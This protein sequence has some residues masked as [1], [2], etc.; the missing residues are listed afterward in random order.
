MKRKLM[1]FLTCLFIGIGLVTAQTQTVTGIVI[2][3]EDGLPIAGASILVKGTSNGTI[4]EIDGKF[5][6]TNVPT[7]V[8]TLQVSYLGMIPQE[9]TIG[10]NLRVVLKSDTQML[11]EIVVTALGIKKSEKSIGFSAT[12]VSG[13]ELTA[14]GSK[15]VVQAMAGKIAGVQVSSNSSDP[16]ASSSIIVR[17]FSSLKGNNQPLFVV[18]GVPMNNTSVF[19]DDLGSGFDYGNGAN[20]V[21]PNDVESM[22]V[23]KG[24]AATALY[25]NRAANGVVLI[26]TKNGQKQEGIGIEYNLSLQTSDILRLPTFQNKYGIGWAGDHT[27]IENGSWGPVMDGSN[28]LWGN[29]Y[30]NSQKY[31][32]FSPIKDNVR[33]F[34]DYGFTYSNNLSFSGGNETTDYF[35]SVSQ[36]SDDG[37][38]PTDADLFDRF[39]GS[40]R[41]S[42]KFSIVKLSTS[43]NYAQ[44]T[45][46]FSP[47]G[48]GLTMINSIYQMPRDINIAALSDYKTDP[49]DTPDYYFTPY[50][51]TNPY[52][53][54]DNIQNSFEQKKIFGKIQADIQIMKELAFTYRF[55]LD[56]TD[57]ENKIGFPKI[58]PAPGTPNAGQ[59]YN[60]GTVSKEMVRR[61]EY[62]HDFFFNYANTFKNL[63][64]VN[65]TAGININER[66]VSSVLASVTG[67]DIPTYYDLS[68]SAATPTVDEDYRM[69]RL[70]GLFA[71]VQLGY[72]NMLYMTFTARNDWS[73]TLPKENNSFFYPGITGSFIFTEVL[74]ESITR[75]LSFGKVRLAWGQTGNDAAPYQTMPYYVQGSIYNE[76]GNINFPL[77]GTNAYSIGNTLASSTLQPEISTETEVGLNLNF[78]NGRI[79]FD[80]TYYHRN[81]DKQIFSLGMDPSTGYSSQV[82]NLGKISNKGVELLLEVV[83]V[84]TKDF[85]WSVT[86]NFTKNKSL[87]VDLPD[88]LGDEISI[89]Q[90]DGNKYS[91]GFVAKEGMPIGTFKTNLP[92]RT[93][94]G[95]IVVDDVY[96]KP[97]LNPDMEYVGDMNYDYELGIGTSLNYKGFGLSVFFDIRQGGLMYSRTKDI[98]YFVGN[99]LQTLYNDRNPFII[100]NSVNK[101]GDSYVENTTPVA[102]GNIWEYFQDGAMNGGAEFLIDKSYIKWRD[103]V[104]SYDFPKK[105]LAKTPLQGVRIAFTGNNL[106]VW[107]PKA[108]SFIDPEMSSFGNDLRGRFGEYTANPSTRK[109]GFNLSVK[110]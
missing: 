84:K 5:T 68:N 44:Q 11:D 54:I 110:F 35:A 52:Y 31:K 39:T 55:G 57:N 58:D 94:D 21:N 13:E 89:M 73:S 24:A 29:I 42:H 45:N 96:G 56:A 37:M 3:E 79:S 46:R 99:S 27:N 7:S 107:T 60:E 50:G 12:T 105:F 88:E 40:F 83:P 70:V 16:G 1:L 17:G 78:F 82:T 95:K 74:P 23:L 100:P 103:L 104:I 49:F 67:L 18:D 80:G 63:F 4:T 109:F 91:T 65:A 72:N 77:G 97:V 102:V 53:L 38:L 9:V 43:I 106:F 86:G 34:F 47:T 41:G 8:K 81:S 90:I 71:D 6:L 64:D 20:L 66:S 32:P 108:N 28:R 15:N 26:N 48:Q 85:S 51:V 61:A 62:N 76:F 69:Q 2:A 22:T 19:S 10:P 59:V 30:N 25:G 36:L 101:V 87:V 33:D 92:L 93:E 98:N 14:A 75:V